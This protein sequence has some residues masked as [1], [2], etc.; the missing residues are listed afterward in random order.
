MARFY[1]NENFPLDVVK[2]LRGLGHDEL[3]SY[4]AKKANQSIPD[5][6]V[7]SFATEQERALLTINRRDFK[8]LHRKA[9]GHAGIIIC[10][11]DMD[12]LGQANRI[13]QSIA[14]HPNLNDQLI[15]VTRPSRK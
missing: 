13:Q 3:T 7:L 1:S 10:T 14:K 12:F 2:F 8:T 9:E 15:S 5:D 11:Q 4:E 6:D